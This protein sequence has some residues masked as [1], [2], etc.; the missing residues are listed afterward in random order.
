MSS[1]HDT[2]DGRFNLYHAEPGGEVRVVK[3]DVE[4][5]EGGL[6]VMVEHFEDFEDFAAVAE[7]ET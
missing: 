1:C 2:R 6:D 3:H 4:E 7:A 5:R